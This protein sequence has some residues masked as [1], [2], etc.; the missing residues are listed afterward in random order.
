MGQR[1]QS[2][3]LLGDARPAAYFIR[4]GA[5]LETRRERSHYSRPRRARRC[6]DE[7]RAAALDDCVFMYGEGSTYTYGAVDE[8]SAFVRSTEPGRGQAFSMKRD[9]LPP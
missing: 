7:R 3:P 2:R 4:A 5:L 6:L 9:E 8:R 1:A